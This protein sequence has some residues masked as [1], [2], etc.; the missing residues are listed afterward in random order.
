MGDRMK[1][2]Q[3]GDP[4]QIRAETFNTFIDAARDFKARQHDVVSQATPAFRQSGIVLIKNNSGY[5][6]QRFD[7]LGIDTPIITPYDNF[8][9]FKNRPALTCSTPDYSKH[10]GRF[11]VLLEPIAAGKLGYAVVSGITVAKINV[12][13][14]C[15]AY[16]D[17][18]PSGRNYLASGQHGAA[19]ILWKES[20]T[21]TKWAL[22]KIGLPQLVRRF[23]L[24]TEL[25]PG[26]VAEA[27]LLDFTGADYTINP[28]VVF[29]VHDSRGLLRSIRTSCST[30]TTAGGSTAAGRGSTRRYAR[31]PGAR[32]SSVTTRPRGKSS[33]CRRSPA[34]SPSPRPSTWAS[35]ILARPW[36]LSMISTRGPIRRL[37]T[38]P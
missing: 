37:S 6:C 32:P 23:E 4:L 5:D 20:G 2:V 13:A 1:K 30:S 35:P 34:R 33:T 19:I 10:V 38:E 26:G 25:T 9:E 11:V 3:P 36:W 18:Q 17:I 24:K 29:Y 22:V 12:S 16:A 7:V 27:Y 31:A 21:G 15:H 28:D 8:E 14:E